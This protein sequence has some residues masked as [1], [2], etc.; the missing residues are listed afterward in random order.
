METN[1]MTITDVAEYLRL[2]EQT[3]QRYV[4]R[5]EIPFHKIRKVIRFR[6]SDIEAWVDNGGICGNKPAADNTPVAAGYGDLFDGAAMGEGETGNDTEH[7]EG[8]V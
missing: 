2:S 7:G 6:V 3:I 4:L 5:R 8:Q 1:L